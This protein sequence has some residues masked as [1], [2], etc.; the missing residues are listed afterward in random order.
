MIPTTV[1]PKG[2]ITKKYDGTITVSFVV[3]DLMKK[4]T[5]HTNFWT[6]CLLNDLVEKDPNDDTRFR[7]KVNAVDL[8]WS[9][10]EEYNDKVIAMF[11]KLNIEIL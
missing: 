1:I 6:F 4:N 9:E 7:S 11:E 2:K 10:E 8:F 5:P 3:D